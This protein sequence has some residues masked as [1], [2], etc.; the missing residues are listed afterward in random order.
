M[1]LSRIIVLS[2]VLVVSALGGAC[3][4]Y[5]SPTEAEFEPLDQLAGIEWYYRNCPSIPMGTPPQHPCR[6]R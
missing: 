3:D 1:K 6:E 2:L 4:N 5:H